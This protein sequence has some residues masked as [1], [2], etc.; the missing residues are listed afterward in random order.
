MGKA[1]YTCVDF[2]GK[3]YKVDADT[4]MKV[5]EIKELAA[6]QAGVPIKEVIS[7]QAMGGWNADEDK[8]E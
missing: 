8:D 1:I 7:E 2:G 4:T 3:K 5:V 6:K